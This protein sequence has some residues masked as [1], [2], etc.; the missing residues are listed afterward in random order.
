MY[1]VK[2]TKRA[3]KD[4]KLLK[5]AK[6]GKQ[7]QK[8]LD[9]L[10]ENPFQSPPPFE[11]LTWDLEGNFSRRINVQHRLVYGIYENEDNLLSPDGTPY[12]GIIKVIRMW[13]HYE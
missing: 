1:L 4:K 8:L 3:E 9:I 12:E 2:L 13:A 5:E 6:L 11:K 7:A 10:E